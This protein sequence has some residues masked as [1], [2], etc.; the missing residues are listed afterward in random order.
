MTKHI[1]QIESLTSQHFESSIQRI[2][3][4]LQKIY[5]ASDNSPEKLLTREETAEMLSISLV[6]LW[7]WT[8]EDIIPSYRIGNKVR[9]KQ[10]EILKSLKKANQ[11]D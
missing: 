9:Y 1:L 8:K 6:T 3:T 2:I 10:S 4:H 11:F 7:K 5:D